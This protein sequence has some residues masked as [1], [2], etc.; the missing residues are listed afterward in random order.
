MSELTDPGDDA[1]SRTTGIFDR[2]AETYDQV[3]V[4]FFSTFGERLVQLAALSPGERVLDIGSG[5][6]AVLFPA[7]EAVSPSGSVLG[8]DLSPAM[9]ERCA[10]DV[11]ARGLDGVEVRVDDAEHPDVEPGSFDAVLAGLVIFFLPDPGAALDSFRTALAPDGRLALSTFGP[12]DDRFAPVFGAV[13]AHIP[14]PPDEERP[15]PDR[16]ARAQDGPFA[17]SGSITALLGEHGFGSVDHLEVDYGI[18]FR[19]PE[20]WVEWSWSHGARQLW[21]MID[22]AD[23]SA[24]HAA[25]LGALSSLT[26]P[27]GSLVHQ[28][29]VRYT[30][31]RR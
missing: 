3:G 13:A 24:A 23:R 29:R 22:E 19:D 27:D 8:I 2:A 10:A 9:V 21:E 1:K 5:R 14:P 15:V 28:W 20:H 30:I 31:A 12:E 4:D 7:A 18:E 16:P 11:A 6:G 17:T 25:A 26:E